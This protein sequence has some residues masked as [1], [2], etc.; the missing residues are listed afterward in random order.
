VQ[1]IKNRNL[2]LVSTN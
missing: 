1:Q 2:V